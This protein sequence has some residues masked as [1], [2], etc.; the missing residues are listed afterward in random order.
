MTD[1]LDLWRSFRSEIPGPTTDAW[2]RA[3]AAIA[4]A[5]AT[6]LS[7]TRAGEDRIRAHKHRVVW[8]IFS[9][10]RWVLGLS[11]ALAAAVVAVG[12]VVAL[13]SSP[14]SATVP[15]NEPYPLAKLLAT[16]QRAAPN[17]PSIERKL[18]AAQKSVPVGKAMRAILSSRGVRVVVDGRAVALAN[19][20]LHTTGFDQNAVATA[21]NNAI[22]DRLNVEEAIAEVE[23]S[24]VGLKRAVAYMTLVALLLKKA[25]ADGTYATVAQAES[26]ASSSYQR[27]E[28]LVGTPRQPKLPAGRTPKTAFFSPAA[29]AGYRQGLTVDHEIAVI[30]GP[31]GDRSPTLARWMKRQIKVTS[32]VID[33]IPGVSAADVAKWLPNG[34]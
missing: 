27:Y 32:V 31:S 3:R 20:A 21:V 9:H 16:V 26:L 15:A 33:G 22:R 14:R 1:D 12:L 5:E 34:L 11:A 18:L 4:L 2:A 17:A 7:A 25:R 30:A 29:I 23:R 19:L 6:E 28:S 13:P 10:R 24:T 8:Q